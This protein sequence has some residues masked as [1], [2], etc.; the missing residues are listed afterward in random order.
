METP[1]RLENLNLDAS[2]LSAD[3]TVDEVRAAVLASGDH[4]SPG[5]DNIRSSFI[6]NEPCIEF[7][8]SLFNYCF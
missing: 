3:I 1:P 5:S 8:H 2:E 6:K 4:K 7:L